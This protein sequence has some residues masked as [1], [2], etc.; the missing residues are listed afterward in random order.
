[1][2]KRWKRKSGYTTPDLT[3]PRKELIKFDLFVNPFY[4]EWNNYRDGFRDFIGDFKKIKNIHGNRG[5]YI[6]KEVLEKRMRMNLKQKKLLKR[7]QAKKSMKKLLGS[8][9][10]WPLYKPKPLN[11]PSPRCTAK[12][13]CLSPKKQCSSH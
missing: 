12:E 11:S 2:R 5:R 7:R 10:I 3:I 8:G 1:M 4:D 13:G 6:C 9:Y